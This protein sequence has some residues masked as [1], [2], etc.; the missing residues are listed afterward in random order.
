MSSEFPRRWVTSSASIRSDGINDYCE[1][2]S[3]IQPTDRQDGKSLHKSDCRVLD[4]DYL[5]LY[6]SGD[7]TQFII[8]SQPRRHKKLT[9]YPDISWLDFVEEYLHGDLRIDQIVLGWGFC[10]TLIV[11]DHFMKDVHTSTLEDCEK[12]INLFLLRLPVE[13]NIVV[14]EKDGGEI[15]FQGENDS[16]VSWQS[17]FH[18]YSLYRKQQREVISREFGI[19]SSRRLS[20]RTSAA[21]QEHLKSSNR[22]EILLN[23]RLSKMKPGYLKVDSEN[24]ISS[25]SKSDYETQTRRASIV[26]SPDDPIIAFFGA[27]PNAGVVDNVIQP[28]SQYGFGAIFPDRARY[29]FLSE[30]GEMT[31]LKNELEHEKDI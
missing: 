22:T 3:E 24:K 16:K 27:V 4:A 28:G 2:C 1:S 10:H 20:G 12:L 19:K 25:L 9:E 29:F 17:A 15:K 14:R 31:E 6:G 13:M 18:S 23:Y 11:Q 21:F 26:F 8:N 30:S 7:F 5:S